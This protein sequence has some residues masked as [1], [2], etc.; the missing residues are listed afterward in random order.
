M[1]Q[2]PLA[3]VQSSFVASEDNTAPVL[4]IFDLS[5]SEIEERKSILAALASAAGNQ[6][7]AAQLLGVSRSTLLNRLDAYRIRRPRKRPG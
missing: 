3:L 2:K 7:R 1:R 6:S 5:S 4:P